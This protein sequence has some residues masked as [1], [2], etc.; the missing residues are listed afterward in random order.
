MLTV[1]AHRHR[2]A[3]NAFITIDALPPGALTTAEIDATVAFAEAEKSAATRKAYA[4][5]WAD[6]ATWCDARGARPAAG[7]AGPRCGLS[8]GSGPGWPQSV[9]RWPPR[10]RHS[11]SPQAGGAGTAGQR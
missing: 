1:P 7:A 6:F 5:D 11:A 2:G 9:N 10:C 8:L 4:Q 3:V